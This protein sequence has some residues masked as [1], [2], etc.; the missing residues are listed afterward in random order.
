MAGTAG[1]ICAPA[2]A[3]TKVLE[4][5][6][7]REEA[8]LDSIRAEVGHEFHEAVWMVSLMIEQF[9][10]ELRWLDKLARD[11]LRRAPARHPAYFE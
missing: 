6:L 9:R 11:V 1:G 3:E 4:N 2:C 5:E 10:A 8:T 7:A